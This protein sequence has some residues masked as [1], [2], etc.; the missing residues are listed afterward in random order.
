MLI[1]EN[2]GTT[3]IGF[4]FEQVRID[5]NT[6]LYYLICTIEVFVHNDVKIVNYVVFNLLQ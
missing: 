6:V 2:S 4:A 1:V 5:S 3:V